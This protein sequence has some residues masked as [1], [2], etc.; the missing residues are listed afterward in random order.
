MHFGFT[1]AAPTLVWATLCYIQIGPVETPG[2]WVMCVG[3]WG[4]RRPFSFSS[5][6]RER[7]KQCRAC[8][9]ILWCN[10]PSAHDKICNHWGLYQRKHE[11]RRFKQSRLIGCHVSQLACL[12]LIKNGKWKQVM[13]GGGVQGFSQTMTWLLDSPKLLSDNENRENSK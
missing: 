5:D 1:L 7:N 13:E 9:L 10:R 12:A 4:F 2:H 11:Q 6:L 8:F 3:D